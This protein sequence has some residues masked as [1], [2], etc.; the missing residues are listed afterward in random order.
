VISI[1]VAL[2][3]AAETVATLSAT[4]AHGRT[5]T[6]GMVTRKRVAPA[7]HGGE[8]HL[9]RDS[10]APIAVRQ[11]AIRFVRDYASWSA[12]RLTA[13]PPGEATKRVIRLLER[14]DPRATPDAGEAAW[15]VRIARASARSFV[16]TS[17]VGNFR[18]GKRTSRWLVVSVPGD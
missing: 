17:T 10:P 14:Q 5:E 2:V 12:A 1:A 13:L 18:I 3:A 16:V 6:R 4:S 9:S 15:S 11:A 8:P 7:P